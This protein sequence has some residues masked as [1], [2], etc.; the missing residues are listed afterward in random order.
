MIKL[1]ILSDDKAVGKAVAA[2]IIDVIKHQ[3]HPVLGL[4]TGSSPL[5]TYQALVKNY[6]THHTDWSKV[7]TFNLDEYVGLTTDNINSYHYFMH[8]N[9]FSHINIL[10]ENTFIPC[11][12]GDYQSYASKYD[13]LIAARQGID[14]QILGVGLNG[15]IGFNEPPAQLNSLTRVVDLT[16]STIKAN[17]RFFNNLAEVP[18]QAVSMGIKSIMQAKKIIIIAIGSNKSAIVKQIMDHKITNQIPVTLLHNHPDVT[19]ITDQ[20]AAAKLSRN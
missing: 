4:A 2:I 8:K 5:L 16:S 6:Q 10:S 12:V 20:L 3:Q 11:G 17:A 15:H 7:T 13:D 14:L 18:K 9:L 19:L 1:Q